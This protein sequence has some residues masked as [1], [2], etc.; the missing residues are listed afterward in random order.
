MN[1]RQKLLE[2]EPEKLQAFYSATRDFSASENVYNQCTFEY[3]RLLLSEWDLKFPDEHLMIFSLCNLLE[4]EGAFKEEEKVFC[5]IPFKY[6]GV[7]FCYSIRKFGEVLYSD[8]DDKVFIKEVMLKLWNAGKIA[9]KLLRN[10]IIESI[11]KG[12]VLIKNQFTNLYAKYLFFQNQAK[13]FFDK[14]V[15]QNIFKRNSSNTRKGFYYLTAMLDSYFSFQEH[16]IVLIFAFRE[17]F[18]SD[19]NLYDVIEM[20]WQDKFKTIFNIKDKEL[21]KHYDR[22]TLIKN[23]YRN[24][25]SHGGFDKEQTYMF[26]KIHDLGYIP[27]NV[28]KG[29]IFTQMHRVETF[30]E[31]INIIE[32]FHSFLNENPKYK[33]ILKILDSGIEIGYTKEDNITLKS[34]IQT[35]EMVESFIEYKLEYIDREMN[36]DW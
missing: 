18:S 12:E 30:E 19:K 6:K 31:I 11:S 2:I 16:M 29:N 17:E 14:P 13:Q 5:E 8:S 36:M 32:G 20:T 7:E 9:D 1:W 15:E 10:P 28:E 4:Y 33:R 23:N 35:D 26:V 25:I 3:K 24:T 21:K 34:A 22:L 27:T